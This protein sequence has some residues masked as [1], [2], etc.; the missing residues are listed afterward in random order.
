MARSTFFALNAVG[1]RFGCLHPLTS[2]C[3]YSSFCLPI[4]LYGCEL[5]CITKTEITMLE[6]VHRKILRT[7][8]GLPLRCP[9]KA[10]QILMGTSSILSFICKRQ[11]SFAHSFSTLPPDSLPRQSF[12]VPCKVSIF[13]GDHFYSLIPFGKVQPALH[14]LTHGWLLQQVGLEEAGKAAVLNKRIP[15][16]S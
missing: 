11:L 14:Q 12:G 4:L 15:G 8:Q 3:L 7:I 1:S 5:W 9:A 10:L 6:R 13:E 16:I 2:F